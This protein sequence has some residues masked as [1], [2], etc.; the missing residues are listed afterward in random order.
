MR[1]LF[2]VLAVAGFALVTGADASA[3]SQEKKKVR[4]PVREQKTPE[5]KFAVTYVAVS[6]GDSSDR[7]FAMPSGGWVRMNIDRNGRPKAMWGQEA[8]GRYWIVDFTCREQQP[9]TEPVLE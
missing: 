8:D 7:Y 9:P 2:V 6:P 1:A 3:Q 4:V 5:T